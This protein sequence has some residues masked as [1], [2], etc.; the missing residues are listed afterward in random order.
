MSAAEADGDYA[1]AAA[2]AQRM[3]EVRPELHAISPFFIQPHEEGYHTGVWYW[4][5]ADRRAYYQSLA[6]R[7]SG[8]AGTLVASLPRT[9]LFRTDP[10]DDG[11]FTG[12]YAPKRSEAGWRLLD[13]TRPFY[14]QGYEDEQGHPYVGYLWYRFS[15]EVPASAVGAKT[16]LYLPVVETEAWC[17]VNGQYAGHRPYA[18]AYIRPT[19]L[20]LDVTSALRPGSNVIALRVSTSLAPAQAADGLLC[21]GFLYAPKGGAAAR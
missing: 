10:H 9:A 17:W 19:P 16:R 20:E 18:E 2:Q 15:V 14:V 1:E 8:K 11:L 13:A 12:W 3:L 4:R 6:D 7:V 5:I 21:R